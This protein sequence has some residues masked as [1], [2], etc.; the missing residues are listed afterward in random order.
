[1]TL[2]NNKKEH[3]PSV[4]MSENRQ[5]V[6]IVHATNMIQHPELSGVI[7]AALLTTALA[8]V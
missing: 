8:L 3:N 1:M 2:V 7:P 6:G 5:N 4:I